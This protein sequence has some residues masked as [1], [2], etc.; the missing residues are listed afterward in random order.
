MTVTE[1]SPRGR[2]FWNT[3]YSRNTQTTERGSR[4]SDFL[5]MTTRTTGAT[6]A[7]TAPSTT[8]THGATIPLRSTRKRWKTRGCGS[9]RTGCKRT[10]MPKTG[11]PDRRT[12]KERTG[13]MGGREHNPQ[14]ARPQTARASPEH[15]PRRGASGALPRGLRSYRHSAEPIKLHL[16][17]HLFI[18]KPHGMLYNNFVSIIMCSIGQK[19]EI[20]SVGTKSITIWILPKP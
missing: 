8:L 1:R 17:P 13:A 15:A 12:D 20:W 6:T 4:G 19:E 3:A 18:D 5:P 2:T 9:C 14:A 7:R 11:A 10:R 16:I